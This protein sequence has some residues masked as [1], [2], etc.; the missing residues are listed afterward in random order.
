MKN[1]IYLDNAATSFPKP[2]CVIESITNYMINNGSNPSRGSSNL[3]LQGNRYV[4]DCR[5]SIA[6]FFNFDKTENVIFTNNITA[7][8]NIILNALIKDGNHIITSTMEHNSVLRPLEKLKSTLNIDVDFIE[9]STEGFVSS[10]LIAAK[11]KKNTKLVI[12]SHASNLTGSIQDIASIGKLCKDNDIFFLVDCAQTAGVIPIDMKD[13]NINALTFTGHKSLFGPQGI[14]GFIIDD[15]IN[16]EM[17]SVFVGGTGSSSYSLE[18]PLDLPDKFECGTLNTPGIVGLHAGIDFINKEGIEKIKETEEEL[19]R[20]A[21]DELS[22]IKNLKIYGSLDAKKRTST[23]LFNIE[24]IDPSDLGFYL[25]SQ[26]KIIT[27]TGLHCAPLAHKTIGSFPAGG[28]RI[29]LGYFNTK[30]EIDYLID[31]L[32]NINWG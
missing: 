19:C 6:N 3:A 14:G 22:K 29:S 32:K 16:Q 30:E 28:V 18:H 4:Y 5:Y 10:D 26:K 15:K 20:Y 2:S 7:S 27:R 31:S 1:S 13:C 17:S 11:I 21:L 25:D 9:A 24:G 12:L 8:I 23:I